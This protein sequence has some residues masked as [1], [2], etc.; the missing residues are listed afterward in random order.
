VIGGGLKIREAIAE[1]CKREDD[2][3]LQDVKYQKDNSL[4]IVSMDRPDIKNAFTDAMLDG[5]QE[6]LT[7]AA[8]D[9]GVRVILLTGREAFSAGGNVKEMAEGKLTSWDMKRYLTDRV[10]P[11][12]LLIEALDK[13]IVACVE[14]PAY[15]AGFDL[16]LA[17][18]IRIASENARFC[19][20]FVKLGLAPGDGGAYFLPRIVGPMKALDILWAGWSRRKRH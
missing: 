11:I 5:L 19:A 6:A 3:K 18:D 20:S 17:C 14:G 16:A 9:P 10:Q 15:G 1:W 13:P 2:M 8:R 4:A 7:D 12:P